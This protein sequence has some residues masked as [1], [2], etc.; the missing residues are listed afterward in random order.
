MKGLGK[1]IFVP[2]PLLK[3]ML[4]LTSAHIKQNPLEDIPIKKVDN[5]ENL[6][7]DI[8]DANLG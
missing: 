2:K 4:I 8:V 1:L 3:K 5:L 7:R 6:L